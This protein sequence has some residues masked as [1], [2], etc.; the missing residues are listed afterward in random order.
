[1]SLGDIH[2][3]E[4]SAE[5]S[6]QSETIDQSYNNSA[7]LTIRNP[8]LEVLILAVTRSDSI[9]DILIRAISGASST[10]PAE[11]DE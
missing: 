11:C 4:T 3:F 8:S 10:P 9:A 7:Y 6:E 5:E 2:L 1:M